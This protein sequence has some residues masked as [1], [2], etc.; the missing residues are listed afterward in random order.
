ME[1]KDFIKEKLSEF[2][3]V[4][5]K[6]HVRYEYKAL[7]G[8]HFVEIIPYEIYQSDACTDWMSA[9]HDE[10]ELYPTC[11]ICFISDNAFVGIDNAEYE[12]SGAEYIPAIVG[13]NEVIIKEQDVCWD[14]VTIF[15]NEGKSDYPVSSFSWNVNDWND[16]HLFHL[17]IIKY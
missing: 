3:S 5:K 16:T 13:R 4:F 6:V 17:S 1:A 12:F 14:D 7:S 11:D 2:V 15:E 8:I 9:V 10:A